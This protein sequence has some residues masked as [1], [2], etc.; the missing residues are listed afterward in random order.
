MPEQD[1]APGQSARSGR[2]DEVL[3][4]HRQRV[5]PEYPIQDRY[6]HQGER[7]RDRRAYRRL[8]MRP[9]STGAHPATGAAPSRTAI[10]ATS[11]NA[12][13]EVLSDLS[14]VC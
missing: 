4:E 10:S 8:S 3:V 6:L 11:S 2:D 13:L 9:S 7:G 12:T 14:N 5:G 1:V